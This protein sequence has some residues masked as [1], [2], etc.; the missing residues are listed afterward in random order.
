MTPAA[1]FIVYLPSI[2][3]ARDAVESVASQLRGAEKSIR[4]T[5]HPW[6]L[7]AQFPRA[8]GFFPYWNHMRKVLERR[9]A[10]SLA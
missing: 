1:P 9:Y 3:N 6:D 7:A 10:G 4:Y 5:R 2:G 8:T